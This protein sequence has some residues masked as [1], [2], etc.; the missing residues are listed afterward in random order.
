LSSVMWAARLSHIRRKWPT[1]PLPA[2]GGRTP[3]QA[4][5]DKDAELPLRAALRVI[6]LLDDRDSRSAS[7][8]TDL[9][10]ELGLSTEPDVDPATAD[11]E[12]LHLERLYMLDTARLDDTKLITLF[13]RAQRYRLLDIVERC[14]SSLAERHELFDREHGVSCYEVYSALAYVATSH[15]NESDALKWIERGRE[16]EPASERAR[17]APL[18][19]LLEVRLHA[20]SEPPEQWVPLLTS[21]LD[22]YRDSKA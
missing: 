15:D 4:A 17:Y 10:A 13:R 22:R 11:I 3:K 18:W 14:A 19:D 5:E 20:D 1:T 8:L 21:V 2:L 7:L 6:E 16:A 12:A 9:R